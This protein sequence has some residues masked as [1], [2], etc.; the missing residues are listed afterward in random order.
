MTHS[1]RAETREG[2]DRHCEATSSIH[3]GLGPC[4]CEARGAWVEETLALF[5]QPDND[6][7]DPHF[8]TMHAGCS[9]DWSGD[10]EAHF[11][12]EDVDHDGV[13]RCRCGATHFDGH[14]VRP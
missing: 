6:G 13:H 3:P 8:D 4:Q 1:P 9:A 7:P 11:C 10:S 14:E 12:A 2:H 5:A